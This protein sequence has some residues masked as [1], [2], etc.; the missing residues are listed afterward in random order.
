[1]RAGRDPLG[2]GLSGLGQDDWTQRETVLRQGETKYFRL[3]IDVNGKTEIQR[4]E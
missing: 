3:S 1:M 2:K 4:S